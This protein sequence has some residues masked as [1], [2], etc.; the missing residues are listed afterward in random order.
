MTTEP[1]KNRPTTKSNWPGKNHIKMLASLESAKAVNNPFCLFFFI[2]QVFC[3]PYF[4][5]YKSKRL[6]FL[7]ND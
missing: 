7:N 3:E 1:L 4:K 2:F 5:T 6:L